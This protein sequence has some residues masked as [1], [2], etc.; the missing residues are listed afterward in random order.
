VMQRLSIE[1]ERKLIHL[2][3]DAYRASEELREFTQR[4]AVYKGT[5]GLADQVEAELKKA[6]GK[7]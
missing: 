2:T 5:K 1:D 7:R 3:R 4:R 6:E